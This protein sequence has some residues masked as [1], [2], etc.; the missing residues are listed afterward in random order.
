VID[1]D[2]DS[3]NQHRA[4]HFRSAEGASTILQGI[5]I[6]GGYANLGGAIRCEDYSSPTI[7]DC[8]LTG[9]HAEGG[10]GA[11]SCGS[12]A[13]PLIIGTLIS[14]NVCDYHGGGMCFWMDCAPRLVDCEFFSN[15]AEYGGGIYCRFADPTLFGCAFSHHWARF[16]G[17]VHF[18]LCSARLDHCTFSDNAVRWCGAGA[19]C[20]DR[21]EVEFHNCT[22][23]SNRATCG[24]AVSSDRDSETI[25]SYCTIVLNDATRGAGVECDFGGRASILNTLI[26][27]SRNGSGVC[28]RDD[29]SQMGVWRCDFFGNPGGDWTG[30]VEHKLGIADNIC[31]D[32]EFCDLESGIFRLREGS[33]CSADSSTYGRIGAWRM[34]CD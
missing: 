26:A 15:S 28:C 10:G 1:C 25:V 6:T 32:P 21:A 27:F 2:G 5:T 22:F 16:G 14:Y 34:G 17:G 9:N 12:G 18:Q 30:C 7:A 31:V 8:I 20:N 3:L 24:G 19:Y 23:F 29:E 4:F 13:S 11:V 33:P